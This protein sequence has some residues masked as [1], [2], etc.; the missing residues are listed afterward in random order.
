MIMEIKNNQLTID[1]PEG[2]EIDKEN[3]TFKCI[4]LKPIKTKPKAEAWAR[5]NL[6]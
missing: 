4:K 6:I 5:K 1:I 2:Y 3:S